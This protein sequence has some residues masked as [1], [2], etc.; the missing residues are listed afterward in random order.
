MDDDFDVISV[1]NV[2]DSIPRCVKVASAPQTDKTNTCVGCNK[3]VSANSTIRKHHNDRKTENVIGKKLCIEK[4]V[5]IL[6]KNIRDMFSL[7]SD[8]GQIS[9]APNT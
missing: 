9:P 7:S 2:H 1:A 4:S 5:K 8:N 6:I 3:L